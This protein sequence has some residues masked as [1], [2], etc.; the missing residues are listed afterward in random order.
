MCVVG[1][2]ALNFPTTAVQRVRA[3]LVNA[4]DIQSLQWSEMGRSLPVSDMAVLVHSDAL[5]LEPY[6][7]GL[8]LSFTSRPR[9]QTGQ[10]VGAEVTVASRDRPQ[11]CV[12]LGLSAVHSLDVLTGPSKGTAGFVK[13]DAQT[14]NVARTT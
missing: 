5:K 12:G 2:V 3:A 11:G 14:P 8:R 7:G 10:L 13:V 4:A 1:G 9:D 6:R